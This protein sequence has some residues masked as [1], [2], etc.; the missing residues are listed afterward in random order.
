MSDKDNPVVWLKYILEFTLLELILLRKVLMNLFFVK[1][2][3]IELT[4]QGKINSLTM[5]YSI[6]MG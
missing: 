6:S 2:E 4:H 5:L 1:I 3:Y